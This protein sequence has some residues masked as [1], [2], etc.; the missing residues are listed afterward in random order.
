[1]GTQFVWV[2]SDRLRREIALKEACTC[3]NCR[4]VWAHKDSADWIVEHF[5]SRSQPVTCLD[6]GVRSVIPSKYLGPRKI[7]REPQP[8]SVPTHTQAHKTWFGRKARDAKTD[9]WDYERG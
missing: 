9:D 4:T 3:P 8:E 5:G 6:C 7:Y 1:M 2:D